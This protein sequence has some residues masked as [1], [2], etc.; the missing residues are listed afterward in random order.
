MCLTLDIPGH[1]SSI[2]GALKHYCSEEVLDGHNKYHC[3][4]CQQKVAACT[5][6]LL[7]PI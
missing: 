3:D 4:C 6:A 1:I 5:S 2:E 7:R